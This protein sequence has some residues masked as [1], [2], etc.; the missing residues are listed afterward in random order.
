MAVPAFLTLNRRETLEGKQT[1]AREILAEGVRTGPS[2]Q[3]NGVFS[4]GLSPACAHYLDIALSEKAEELNVWAGRRGK[5]ITSTTILDKHPDTFRLEQGHPMPTPDDCVAV[6]LPLSSAAVEVES[7]GDG[8]EAAAAARAVWEP[9][10]AMLV[11]AGEA[12]SVVEGS[13]HFVYVL[14]RMEAAE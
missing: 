1:A 11:A 2:Q 13:T 8:A 5:R 14:V 10:T 9:E 3:A 4:Y 12:F 7:K 6:V